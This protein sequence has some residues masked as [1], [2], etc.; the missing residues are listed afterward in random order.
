M[1]WPFSLIN[2]FSHEISIRIHLTIFNM[3]S[4]MHLT[5]IWNGIGS[6]IPGIFYL[7]EYVLI[8][9]VQKI[10]LTITAWNE[11]CRSRII[12]IRIYNRGQII[13]TWNKICERNFLNFYWTKFWMLQMYLNSSE[14]RNGLNI[15]T[16]EFFSVFL[17]RHCSFCCNL[18]FSYV[19]YSLW[20]SR[21]E[22]VSHV[23]L[24]HEFVPLPYGCWSS[25]LNFC[26]V[27][28]LFS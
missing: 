12:L 21:K 8:L 1:G 20:S 13:Y 24:D 19:D 11:G 22:T 27:K 16:V 10:V 18:L 28:V 25:T 26:C 23:L 9:F 7:F 6:K 3:F 15:F 5:R 2:P 4:K 14:F 17:I